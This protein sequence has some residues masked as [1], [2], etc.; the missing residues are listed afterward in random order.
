[1]SKHDMTELTKA[2]TDQG[3]EVVTKGVRHPKVYKVTTN[4]DGGER[5][6]LITT[7]PSSSSSGRN[8]DN[9]LPYLRRAG[10]VW[11]NR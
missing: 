3:F 7:L 6:R 8:L 10:F 9:T 5:R 11:K 1:M 4:P 2:L